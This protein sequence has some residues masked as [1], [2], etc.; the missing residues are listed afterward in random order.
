VQSYTIMKSST[1]F[2]TFEQY[3]G[4]LR[5]YFAGLAMQGLVKDFVWQDSITG[6]IHSHD[7]VAK[8]AV[9]VADEL[10]KDLE[11]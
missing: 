10:L 4:Y 5:T 1:D 8:V 3:Q 2:Q 9:M 11:L 6:E 7:Y